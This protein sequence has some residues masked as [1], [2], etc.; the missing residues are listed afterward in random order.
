MDILF[1]LFGQVLEFTEPFVYTCMP[2]LFIYAIYSLYS[3]GQR[4]EFV[5]NI[6]TLLTTLGIFGTFAGILMGLR[7]FDATNIDGSIEGLLTGL[8]TA[9][10]T[11]FW[12]IFL[13]MLLKAIQSLRFN[14]NDVEAVKSA[15]PEE[16]LAAIVQQNESINKLL[17]AIGGESDGSLVSQLKLLRGD[18]NDN[19]KLSIKSQQITAETIKIINEQLTHQQELFTEFSDKLWIKMQDFADM[20]SKSATE[21]VIEALKQVIIDFN[22]NLTEQFGDNFKQLNEAVK[23]LVTWQENYKIQISEMIEQYKLGVASISAT[24]VSVAKI[25]N[26]SKVIPET[27]SNLKQIIEI[28]QH[29]LTE[30]ERHLE[31]FKEIRD[32]AV[33]AV[34]EIRK[35]IDD[36][37]KAIADSVEVASTHYKELLSE[38]DKYIQTHI[39][40]SNEL[41]EKF[42][43]NTK[44]GVETIGE[45]LSESASKVE[46][47]ISEGA[48]EFTDKIHQTNAG[49]QTTAD[50]VT[51]QTEVIKNH[52]K[53]TVED[54]NDH[55]RQMIQTLVDDS[56]ALA[57]TLID[58]NKALVSDTSSVR[59]NVTQS[60][61]AMQKRLENSLDD[62][63]MSQSQHM[64]KVFANLDASL[65]EQVGKTGEAVEKQIGIIDQTMQQEIERVMTQMGKALGQI[66]NQFVQDYSKLVSRMNTIVNKTV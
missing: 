59:D 6:P 19:Q 24:E 29:Q 26:E 48:N 17:I 38:S 66:S 16:I 60:I 22:N 12:G 21:T 55:V 37:V 41:L 14:S 27:M 44:N 65:K 5:A 49:L 23:E 7:A 15:S 25:S 57:T 43:N 4:T 46:K 33:E 54:L 11:S 28:N 42:V 31:A 56:K 45:K 47:V 8:K 35:Q 32:R 58:A 63:F 3:G 62:V 52:L 13:S 20:L 36:T 61:E 9:F 1:S 10:F 51:S 2:L 53:D 64:T 30:L 39:S 18:M 50:H 34:P 40:S